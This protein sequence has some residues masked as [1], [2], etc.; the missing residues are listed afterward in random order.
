[1]ESVSNFRA[2][3]QAYACPHTALGTFCALTAMII[4]VS[5]SPTNLSRFEQGNGLPN[6]SST[7]LG[8]H[9]VQMVKRN[10]HTDKTSLTFDQLK[11]HGT[12]PEILKVVTD[13]QAVE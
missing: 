3:V 2:P 6:A 4:Y 12:S 8:T 11:E 9:Q 10:E 7:A 13:S 1:M 5:V